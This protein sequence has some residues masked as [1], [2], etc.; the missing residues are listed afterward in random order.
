MGC[1]E[2][3]EQYFKQ[4]SDDLDSCLNIK[5]MMQ[6]PLKSK[7]FAVSQKWVESFNMYLLNL[8]QFH[9]ILNKC[10]KD[11]LKEGAHKQLLNEDIK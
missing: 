8:Q 11:D 2:Q 4:V 7:A 1:R 6:A 9:Q 3:M 10:L 5:E